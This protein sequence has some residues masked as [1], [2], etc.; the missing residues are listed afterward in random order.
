ML[1]YVELIPQFIRFPSSVILNPLNLLK[2]GCSLCGNDPRREKLWTV[3]VFSICYWKGCRCCQT[4]MLRDVPAPLQHFLLH[5]Q[6]TGKQC[7]ICKMTVFVPSSNHSPWLQPASLGLVWLVLELA[8]DG[9]K[10][11]DCDFPDIDSKSS[12]YLWSTDLNGSAPHFLQLLQERHSCTES[13]FPLLAAAVS[14]P[15]PGP[16]K[17]SLYYGSSPLEGIIY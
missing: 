13:A 9:S 3:L 1:G 7:W 5:W 17:L 2:T 4:S 8:W 12:R 11:S 15:Y 6:G 16:A 14:F 10:L